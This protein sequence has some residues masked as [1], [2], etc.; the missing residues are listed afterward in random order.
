MVKLFISFLTVKILY[1]NLK[2]AENYFVSWPYLY[3]VNLSV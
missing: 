2:C 1:E 3:V